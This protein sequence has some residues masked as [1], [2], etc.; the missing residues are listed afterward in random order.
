MCSSDLNAG[1]S[2]LAHILNGFWSSQ[3]GAQL[4]LDQFAEISDKMLL[5]PEITG[6]KTLHVGLIKS[7]KL[8]ALAS[9]ECRSDG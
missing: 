3:A 2:F 9:L 8:Q 7:L 6:T 1:K 4:Q 5:S